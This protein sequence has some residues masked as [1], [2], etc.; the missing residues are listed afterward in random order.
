RPPDTHSVT[1]SSPTR[2]S[3]ALGHSPHVPATITRY[4]APHPWQFAFLF[5]LAR[6][7]PFN[8]SR[9]VEKQQLPGQSGFLTRLFKGKK[10]A[11]ERSEE[12]TSEL[13]S[14]EKLVCRL[15]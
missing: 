8:M 4:S 15:L 12:H 6:G 3:S 5:Y 13:Q 14:R 11:S 7:L 2:P 10:R 1:P 9:A